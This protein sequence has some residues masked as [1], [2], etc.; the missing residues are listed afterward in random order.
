[1]FTK[2]SRVREREEVYTIKQ[3]K[4]NILILFNKKRVQT[5]IGINFVLGVRLLVIIGI[6]MMDAYLRVAINVDKDTL[7]KQLINVFHVR[8]DVKFVLC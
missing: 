6:V 7:E 4:V 2:F 8:M 5:N 1:L 3:I